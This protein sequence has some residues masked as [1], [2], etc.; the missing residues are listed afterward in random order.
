MT[1]PIATSRAA[2]VVSWRSKARHAAPTD[3]AAQSVMRAG[4]A[5]ITPIASSVA[6]VEVAALQEIR[7][8][9]VLLDVEMDLDEVLHDLRRG[10]ADGPGVV[11]EGEDDEL[12]GRVL[13]IPVHRGPRHE[14]HEPR[15]VRQPALRVALAELGGTGLPG[16]LDRKVD[17]VVRVAHEDDVAG[18]LAHR[19]EHALRDVQLVEQ[20][21]LERLDDG[22]VRRRDLS[23]ELGLIQL[24]AVRERRVRVDELDG[25]RDVV[26]LPDP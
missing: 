9:V 24:A 21:R 5:R 2:Y 1:S 13:E 4:C 8:A 20:L 23:D 15:V 14:P 25:R 3:L 16:D 26:A 11:G 12:G 7:D 6:L 18:R 10:I 22:P 19:P 17:E